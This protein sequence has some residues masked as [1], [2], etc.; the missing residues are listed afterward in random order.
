MKKKWITGVLTLGLA[1]ILVGCGTNTNNTGNENNTENTGTEETAEATEALYLT[2]I[3][4]EEYVTLGEYKGLEFT[5]EKKE[6]TEDMVEQYI[7]FLLMQQ[8][9]VQPVIDRDT[10][11]TGDVANI[12]YVGTKDGVAFDG[13]T[14]EGFDLT[15]GSGQFI[16]GFEEGLVG[17]K[18]GETVDLNLAFPENY[19]MPDLA[20]AEVVFT[21]TVNSISANKT[22]ELTDEWVKSQNLEEAAT[23]AEYRE[24]VRT[25]LETQA[26]D[27][28]NYD[29]QIELI[30]KAMENATI[31]EPPMELQ[32]RY[33]DIAKSQA[34]SQATYYGVDLETFVS[35]SFGVTLEQFEE[36]LA[37]GALETAKQ[38]L[39]CKRITE[40]ENLT[41]TDEDMN[42]KIE[43]NY[44][45][46]GYPSVDA[47]KEVVDLE[48]Y[49]DSL[50]ID[51]ALQFLVENAAQ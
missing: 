3:S 2:E 17:V 22:P 26:Q 33:K 19:H 47:F 8:S 29:V 50:L 21:V 32:A 30:K 48:E 28:Y 5:A 13:G 14:A 6:I 51:K 40:V 35:T 45:G 10:V 31:Q 42:Q 11:E 12:D 36:E 24:F 46:W 4:A 9:E 23:A 37:A 15:I 38:A 43:E 49:R 39:V 7:S 16:P 41:V 44:A 18:V 20:G 1:A 25:F 27:T 34:E